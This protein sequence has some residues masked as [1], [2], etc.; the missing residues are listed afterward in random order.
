MASLCSGRRRAVQPRSPGLRPRPPRPPRS[1]R[2]A[3]CGRA[4]PPR[5]ATES[6]SGLTWAITPSR[7]ATLTATATSPTATSNQARGRANLR[8]VVSRTPMLLV[9]RQHLRP[10]EV[11]AVRRR[12]ARSARGRAGPS[13]PGSAPARR[14][15]RR[16]A[17]AAAEPPARAAGRGRRRWSPAAGSR[18]SDPPRRAASSPS[19]T[20]VTFARPAGSRVPAPTPTPCTWSAGRSWQRSASVTTSAM[21]VGVVSSPE[22]PALTRQP[23]GQLDH[24]GHRNRQLAV[25]GPDRS[26]A[27]GDRTGAHG[28]DPQVV[29]GRGTRPPRRRSSPARPPRGSAPASGSMPC[30]R[31]SASASRANTASARSRTGSGR[32]A[33]S[34]M[35]RTVTQVRCGGSAVATGRPRPWWPAVRPGSPRSW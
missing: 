14:R 15:P 11:G 3:G 32:S 26:G 8:Y 12:S 2:R 34:I 10:Q 30:T 13:C 35:V 9:R 27:E 28:V 16:P 18:S 5:S 29:Q 1:A 7:E 24:G 23:R 22:P 21:P 33:F 17:A 25:G 4:S 31:A 19:T 20:R 6:N